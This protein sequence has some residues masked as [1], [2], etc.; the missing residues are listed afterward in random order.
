MDFLLFSFIQS[1]QPLTAPFFQVTEVGLQCFD[2]VCLNNC[3]V[4]QHC[5]LCLLA[6]CCGVSG[7]CSALLRCVSVLH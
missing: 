3:F 5:G 6:A 1:D 4:L 7:D 2:T